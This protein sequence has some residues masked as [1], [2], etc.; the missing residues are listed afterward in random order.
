[1]K[2]IFLFKRTP[3]IDHLLPIAY[4][5]I[6]NSDILS[7][8]IYFINYLPDIT[9]LKYKNDKRLIYLNS[10]GINLKIPK[11]I[12]LF[13][14]VITTLQNQ[15]NLSLISRYLQPYIGQILSAKLE[16]KQI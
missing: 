6:K 13:F 14:L 12:N 4:S 15:K 7:K 8:N 9:L 16:W 1:M 11:I 3:D 2:Y 10:L 5:L